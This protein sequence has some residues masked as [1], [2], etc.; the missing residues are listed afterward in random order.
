MMLEHE[1][2]EGGIILSGR[3]EVTVG[4]A[5]RILGAGDAYYFNSRQPHR[6]RNVG[7]EACTLVSSCSP[8]TF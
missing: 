2:E 7:N 6:F 1:G 4:E 5:T 3:L 8:P